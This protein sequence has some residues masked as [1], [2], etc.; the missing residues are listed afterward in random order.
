MAPPPKVYPDDWRQG[1]GAYR[2]NFSAVLGRIQ[3]A[4]FGRFVVGVAL[5][6]DPRYCPSPNPA[7]GAKIV[8]AIRFTLIDRSDSGRRRPAFTN[9]IGATTRRFIG[10]AYLHGDY[11]NLR[12]AGERTGVEMG[13]FAA[14]M[15]ST[16]LGP[17]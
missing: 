7:I 8:H 14:G 3:A 6:E 11:S 13:T 12:H 9:L 4:E 1:M 2:R 15:Y 10:D 5:R 16:S 17:N